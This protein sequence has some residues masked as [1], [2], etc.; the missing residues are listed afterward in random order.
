M[1]HAAEYLYRGTTA[2]WV[3]THANQTLPM[4][5]TTTDPLVA[6]YFAL[7]CLFHGHSIVQ[8]VLRSSVERFIGPSNHFDVLESAINLGMKPQDI[9]EYVIHFIDADDTREIL[10][11][12]GFDQVPY[13]IYGRSALD[14]ELEL[15]YRQGYR[16]TREQVREFNRLAFEVGS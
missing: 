14:D 1:D 4:T 7:E 2:G 12:M 8:F 6:T 11:S 10:E 15:S 16:L 3:G 5:C 13:Q 9:L